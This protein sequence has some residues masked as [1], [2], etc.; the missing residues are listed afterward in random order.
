M[1]ESSYKFVGLGITIGVHVAVGLAIAVAAG[2]GDAKAESPFDAQK[3]HV[4]EAQLAFRSKPPPKQPQKRRRSA[5]KTRKVP[6]VSRDA[7]K[8]IDPNK[9]DKKQDEP[10]WRKFK[11]KTSDEED[12]SNVDEDLEAGKKAP[13]IGSFDGSKYGQI[14]VKESKGHPFLGRIAAEMHKY[15]AIPEFE[16]GNGAAVGCIR[17]DIK[18]KIP[19]T[20]LW[21]KSSNANINAAITQGLLKLQKQRNKKPIKVPEVLLQYTTFWTCFKL[22]QKAK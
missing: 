11:D 10:D 17:L 2:S 6:G 7:D 8:K 3:V 12:D 16:K 13:E 20:K 1:S 22:E 21:K 14:G 9:K 18:G 5:R 19:A 4:V 15:S